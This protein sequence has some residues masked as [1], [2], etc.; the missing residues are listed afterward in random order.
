MKLRG[1]P[2]ESLFKHYRVILVRRFGATAEVVPEARIGCVH[3]AA[4]HSAR[5]QGPVGVLDDFV[6]KLVSALRVLLLHYLQALD[7]LVRPCT[8]RE[9]RY[10]VTVFEAEVVADDDADVLEFKPL[11]GVDAAR[12][13][14]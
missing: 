7:G 14:D 12:F 13:I 9:V 2:F 4:F 5:H 3:V 8:L 10:K 11:R 1:A 6:G